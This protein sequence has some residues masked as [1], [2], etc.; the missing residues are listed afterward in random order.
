MLFH[1]QFTPPY[2]AQCNPTERV[3]KVIKTMIAQYVKGDQRSWDEQL[4]ELQIALNTSVQETT[5]VTPAY[6]NFGRELRIPRIFA[7]DSKL[8]ELQPHP[9]EKERIKRIRE[10]QEIV[11]INLAKARS[12]QAKYY[13]L[14]HREPSLWVIHVPCLIIYYLF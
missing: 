11:K 14:R 3:N 8:K 4:V 13:N 6:A 9:S 5:G 2:V 10:I 1:Q 7:D 12:V